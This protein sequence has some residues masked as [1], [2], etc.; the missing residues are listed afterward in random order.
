MKNFEFQKRKRIFVAILVIGIL[1]ISLYFLILSPATRPQ[2]FHTANY[3]TVGIRL[4]GQ[5]SNAT[6]ILPLPVYNGTPQIGCNIV[7]DDILR[8]EDY[9]ISIIEEGEGVYV[10]IFIPSLTATNNDAYLVD[11][12]CIDFPD[13][14]SAFIP[15]NT[16]QPI[17]NE[18]VF[19]PKN[20]LTSQKPGSEYS[21]T[22]Y[23][24]DY[25]PVI[26]RYQIPVYAEYSATPDTIVKIFARVSGMNQWAELGT[27]F[28][29]SYEDTYQHVL[30]GSSEGWYMADGTMETG[31]G[32]YLDT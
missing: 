27:Y 17:G 1:F 24:A 6:F 29:N 18:P 13:S 32:K 21:L 19:L 7:T 20:N 30:Q 3:F 9:S 2:E 5:T 25:H 31:E 11:M 8:Y 28:T 26:T 4:N 15:I 10:K 12:S 23:G 14:D 22:W 16:R